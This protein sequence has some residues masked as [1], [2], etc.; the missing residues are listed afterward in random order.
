M[1]SLGSTNGSEH[2]F[3]GRISQP[4]LE[5]ASIVSSI[6]KLR[7][8]ALTNIGFMLRSVNTEVQLTQCWESENKN[9]SNLVQILL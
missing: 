4:Q 3:G 7:L 8:K 2:T 9:S 1:P 5:V 6:V